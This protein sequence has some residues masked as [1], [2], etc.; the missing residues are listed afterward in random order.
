MQPR[1]LRRDGCAKEG[2]LAPTTGRR[3][4]LMLGPRP[5]DR[6]SFRSFGRNTPMTG[7]TTVNLELRSLRLLWEVGRR[8]PASRSFGL[9]MLVVRSSGPRPFSPNERSGYGSWRSALFRTPLARAPV[10][11]TAHGRVP[12]HVSPHAATPLVRTPVAATPLVRTPILRWVPLAALRLFGPARKFPPRPGFRT[13][14]GR[15]TH[16]RTL[17][18]RIPTCWSPSPRSPFPWSPCFGT[19]RSFAVR[20]SCIRLSGLRS[21]AGALFRGP[22]FPGGL[23]SPETD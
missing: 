12:V 8:T 7:P 17:V 13:A 9:R 5:D 22:V 20:L 21:L 23:E 18:P 14:S 4:G 3:G 10:F 6:V 2:P 16:A 15:A 19:T 11:G 1:A